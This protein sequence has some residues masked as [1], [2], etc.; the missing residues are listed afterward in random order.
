[1]YKLYIELFLYEHLHSMRHTQEQANL[2]GYIQTVLWK[3]WRETEVMLFTHKN[4]LQGGIFPLLVLLAAFSVYEPWRLG[5]SWIGSPT[6]LVGFILFL[7]L[8]MVGTMIPDSFAGERERHTFESLLTTPLPN[9]AILLGKI[10][11]VVGY[12]WGLTLL[13][14]VVGLM[15]INLIH[16]HS[17]YLLYP[18]GLGIFTIALSLMVSLFTAS[19]G[20]LTS[21]HAPTV[22][23]AQRQMGIIISL[24]LLPLAFLIGPFAPTAWKLKVSQ[25]LATIGMTNLTIIVG[26]ILIMLSVAL[27]LLALIRFNRTQ[28]LLD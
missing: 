20:A 8:V 26:C 2:I 22:Q 25:I 28:M 23:E 9:H 12:S 6:M 19:A 7:P 14:M 21:L 4:L 13:G 1:M 18:V 15:T 3:E 17:G 5:S 24:P 10:G 27:I 11:A 16:A